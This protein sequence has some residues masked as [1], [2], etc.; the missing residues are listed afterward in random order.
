MMI[1]PYI[2]KQREKLISLRRYFHMHPEVSMQEFHTAERIEEELDK[3]H[4]P[5][6]R[7]GETGVLGGSS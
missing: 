3:L 4:I 5:H 6:R 1:K 7:V 2:E